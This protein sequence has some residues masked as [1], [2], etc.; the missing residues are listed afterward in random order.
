MGV[1]RRGVRGRGLTSVDK[2]TEE[3][4]VD[5]TGRRDRGRETDPTMCLSSTHYKVQ[6]SPFNSLQPYTYSCS[7]ASSR[8]SLIL[9]MLFAR[10]LSLIAVLYLPIILLMLFRFLSL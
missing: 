3:E 1:A 5:V 6:F 8:C 10:S 9:I 4:W 7:L 2:G